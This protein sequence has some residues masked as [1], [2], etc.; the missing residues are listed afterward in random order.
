MAGRLLLGAAGACAPGPFVERAYHGLV[1]DGRYIEPQAYADFLRGVIAEAEGDSKGA[2]AAYGQAARADSGAAEAWARIGAVRCASSAADARGAGDAVERAL[3]IDSR[4][5][6]AWTVTARCALGRGD[7]KAAHDAARRAAEL[8]PDADGANALVAGTI[9]AD[10]VAEAAAARESLIA[11]TVTARDPVSAWGSL[12]SWAHARDD[13]AL[14]SRALEAL[15]RVAP[16]RRDTVTS[17]AE[18]LAGLGE[19]TAARAVAAA[20]AD[21]SD[22]PLPEARQPLG[23]RLAV[24]EAIARDDTLTTR[25]RVT[26]ARLGLDEAAARALLAGQRDLA[27]D[28]AATVARAEPAARGARL[29]LA[30]GAGRGADLLGASW[31]ARGNVAHVSAAVWVAFAD[32]LGH[33]VSPGEARRTLAAIDHE[34]VVPGDELVSRASVDLAARGLIDPEA[35]SADGRVEFA[36]LRARGSGE[37]LAMPDGRSLDLRHEYLALAL[38]APGSPRAKELGERFSRIASPD[39]VATVALVLARLAPGAQVDP[40]AAGAAG[41][42]LARDPADALL[43]AAALRVAEK[44]GESSVAERAR[45]GLAA[46]S[47]P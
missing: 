19:I 43:V 5:A 7:L 9:P 34:A 6:G 31:E 8:D 40:G 38:T 10:R 30:A 16:A 23:A 12:E 47:P 24:D 46:L 11:L 32:A 27:R 42:L 28:L 13:V 3:A 36:M 45:A 21:A 44:T 39:R 17:G 33:A 20:A 14:W 29:V 41:A 18:E 26:R 2:L 1:V 25:S 37:G 4:Y 22:E 35:L 15:A